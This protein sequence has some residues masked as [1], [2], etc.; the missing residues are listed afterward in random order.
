MD[1]SLAPERRAG[2]LA[3]PVGDD[4]VHVH[5]ELRPAASHPDVQWKH[6]VVLA[7]ENLI[8]CPHNELEALVIE[9]LPGMV[10]DGRAFFQCGVSRDHLSWDQVESDTKMLQRTFGLRAP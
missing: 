9:A 10:G 8:A 5:V 6:I 1:R 4:L 2:E 3:T 7:H